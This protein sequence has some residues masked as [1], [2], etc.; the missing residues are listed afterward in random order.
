MKKI[1]V[2]KEWR[3]DGYIKSHLRKIWR[4]SPQRRRCLQSKACLLCGNK[5]EKLFADHESPV[6][7]PH[8]GFEDW[9]VYIQ[10]LFNGRLQ[11]ICGTCHKA[12][13]KE[14]NS[15]RRASRKARKELK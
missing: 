12:K 11:A 6:V 3:Y 9:N 5:K 10:R 8:K 7:D 13:S 2:K 1:K 14:E 4:W 15:Q